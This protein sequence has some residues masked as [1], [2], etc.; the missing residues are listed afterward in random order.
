[1]CLS[2]LDRFF[3]LLIGAHNLE[4]PQP[5]Q[6][7]YNASIQV[8]NFLFTYGAVVTFPWRLANAVHL[9]VADETRPFAC[10]HDFYGRP[11][12]ALWFHI[13]WAPRSR[14]VL[15]LLGNTIFQL[16]NQGTRLKYYSH[17]AR[18]AMAA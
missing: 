2:A 1:M 6:D 16:I 14:I 13:P 8:L 9:W 12:K 18:G 15:L 3:F 17:D 4:T 11:T 7:V 5:W 10:G